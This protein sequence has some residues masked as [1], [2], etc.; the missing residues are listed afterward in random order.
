MLISPM[1]KDK[2][3]KTVLKCSALCIYYTISYKTKESMSKNKK[4]LKKLCKYIDNFY[5]MIILLN[6]LI[7]NV[8]II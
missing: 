2:V 8:I 4:W 1:K 3:E 5:L 7:L 6:N